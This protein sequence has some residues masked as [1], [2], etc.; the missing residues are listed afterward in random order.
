MIVVWARF[1]DDWADQ[2]A[3]VTL[4]A[5][6][7]RAYVESILYASRFTTDGVIPAE[8]LRSRDRRAMPTLIK[9]GLWEDRGAGTVY[10]PLWRDHVPSRED[11]SKSRSAT[12]DRQ[13]R[14]RESR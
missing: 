10:A 6:A 8:A 3:V 13:R 14:H 11:L 1:S 4:T 12:A 2:P 5:S 7:F 9:A